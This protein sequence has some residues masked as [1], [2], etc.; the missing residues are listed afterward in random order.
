MKRK[1]EKE[2]T[3]VVDSREQRPYRFKGSV[4]KALKAG[5]YS[6]LGLEDRVAIERKSKK[7]AYASLG[8]NRPRFEREAKRLA[9]YDYAAIVIESDLAGFLQP[10]AF[11]R[12]SPKAALNSLVSWSVKYGVHVFF[13]S[14]RRHAK[15]LVYRILEKYWKHRGG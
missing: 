15:A 8:M 6:I 7:D 9:E 1:T 4:T 10:P 5:D 11:T 14:D 2:I 12:L 13:A 3:V